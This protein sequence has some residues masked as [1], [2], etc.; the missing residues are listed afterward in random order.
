MIKLIFRIAGLIVLAGIA[1]HAIG[2]IRRRKQMD[3]EAENFAY[4]K[5]ES[6]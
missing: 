4:W 2:K 6:V 1:A 5:Y 3:C